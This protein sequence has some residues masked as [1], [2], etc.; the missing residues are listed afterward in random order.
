[1]KELYIIGTGSQARYV[2][3]NLKDSR[4]YHVK[5]L[6]DIENKKN[7]GQIV[8]G[9]M[10]VGFIGEVEKIIAKDSFL[11]VAYGDNSKKEK[12]VK[13]LLEKEYKFGKAIS[14]ES[15]ISKGVEIG[16]GSIINPNVTI[17]PNARIGNHVIIHSGAVIEHDNVMGDF[18]NIAPGV[19]TAGNVRVGKRS[20]LY[21]GVNVVPKIKIGEDCVIG[22]GSLVLN[23]LEKKIKAFG[24]PAKPK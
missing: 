8:N 14:K 21:T 2:I 3:E 12:I 16:E 6:I 9:I 4:E 20:Y 24:I 11:I 23:D 18:V 1:M 7:K 15:Y 10:T 5:G 13:D 19:H 17:M 22:A